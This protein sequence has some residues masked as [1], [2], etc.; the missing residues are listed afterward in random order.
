MVD[1]ISSFVA[2]MRCTFGM[3]FNKEVAVTKEQKRRAYLIGAALAAVLAAALTLIFQMCAFADVYTSIGNMFDNIK[4]SLKTVIIALGAL[5][6]VVIGIKWIM[7]AISGD[8]QG[9]Q[10]SKKMIFWIVAG[11][12]IYLLADTIIDTVMALNV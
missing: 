5:A 4:S 6:I 3:A 7:A 1:R 11:V 12:A 10:S 9:I 2:C 8:P